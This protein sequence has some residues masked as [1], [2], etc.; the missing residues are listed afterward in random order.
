[1]SN[2]IFGTKF[3]FFVNSSLDEYQNFSKVIA[4]VDFELVNSEDKLRK[5]QSKDRNP[6]GML[7]ISFYQV[8]LIEN[9]NSPLCDKL[10]PPK[11]IRTYCHEI[12]PAPKLDVW[13]N[14]DHR[15]DSLIFSMVD[16]YGN[17]VEKIEFYGL[18]VMS[19]RCSFNYGENKESTRKV[20]LSFREYKKTFP[21]IW[22][23]N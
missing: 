3:R 19:D 2:I 8:F 4:G 17:A 20:K 23:N 9:I 18:I 5:K 16:E 11:N 7:E 22:S 13:I 14:E 21:P 1:M 6:G 10:P 12:L 15:K